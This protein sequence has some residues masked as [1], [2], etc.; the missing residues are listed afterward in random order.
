VITPTSG[1]GGFGAP[2]CSSLPHALSASRL[3]HNNDVL[4]IEDFM[5][6]GTPELAGSVFLVG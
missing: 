3:R 6:W 2:F 4:N 5:G 1:G